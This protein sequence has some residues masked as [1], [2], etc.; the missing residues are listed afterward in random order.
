MVWMARNFRVVW[1]S[2]NSSGFMAEEAV[3]GAGE[4]TLGRVVQLGLKRTRQDS[5]IASRPGNRFRNS[6]LRA[7]DSTTALI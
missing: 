1:S 2:G 6:S 4:A 5:T 3:N 7:N